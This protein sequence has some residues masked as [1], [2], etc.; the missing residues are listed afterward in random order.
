MEEVKNEVPA[1]PTSINAKGF[2]LK[3]KAFSN[4]QGF[5]EAMR[6]VSLCTAYPTLKQKYRIKR[7][8]DTLEQELKNF[9]E[10]QKDFN[11]LEGD[12]FKSKMDELLDMS[13]DV[14][15]SRLSKEELE[16]IPNL[17][18]ADLYALEFV[19]DVEGL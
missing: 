5:I 15:W 3:Y 1:E 18:P 7:L 6:K 9:F 16:C 11:K 14:K 17:S 10:I 2:K 13:V 8:T 19:A 4:P 12:E